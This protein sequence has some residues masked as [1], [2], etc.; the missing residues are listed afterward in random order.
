MKTLIVCASKYGSTLEIGKWLA[1][2]PGGGCLVDKAGSMPDSWA[3][4]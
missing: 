2:R 3:G 4:R 1:E